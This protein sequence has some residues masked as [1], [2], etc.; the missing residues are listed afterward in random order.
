MKKTLCLTTAFFLLGSAASQ[1]SA[2]EQVDSSGGFTLGVQQVEINRNSAKFN[3][4]R[5]IRDGFYLYDFWFDL[6]ADREFVMFNGSN[7]LRDDQSIDFRVGAFGSWSFEVNRNEIPH[8]LSN[9]ARTPFINQGDGLFTVPSPVG[10][11]VTDVG[12]PAVATSGYNLAPTQAQAN[13]GLL[14][15]NDAATAA[16]LGTHLRP[17]DLGTQ[18]NKTAGTFRFSP[19]GGLNLS[20]S[21]SDERKDGSKIT[22]GPIGDR[23]PRTLNVQLPEPID[24]VTRELKFAAEYNQAAYQAQFTYLYSDFNNKI[25]TLNWQNIYARTGVE[26]ADP[27]YD[28]WAGHR[29]ATFGQ[30]SLQPDNTYQNAALSLGINLPMA[31]RLAATAAYGLMRQDERLL[32]YSTSSFGTTSLGAARELPRSR[33]D[34]DIDTMLLKVDYTLNPF[35]RLNLRAFFRYYD[36][37][38]DTPRDQ[39]WYV[40][41]DTVV[42]NEAGT[43]GNIPSGNPTSKNQRVSLA[44]A[45]DQM[46]YGLDTSFNLPFWRTTLGLGYEREEID[47]DFREANTDENM[48]RVSV[49]ARPAN[50]VTIRAKY[51]FGDRE[52]DGYNNTVTR[53]SYW[54]TNN[55]TGTELTGTDLDNPLVSFSNHPDMRKYDVS[56]RERNQFDLSTNIMPLSGVNLSTSYLYRK[57]DYGSG[58]RPVAGLADVP[59]DTVRNPTTDAITNVEKGALTP[60]DQLGLLETKTQR[61]AVEA[62]YAANDRLTLTAFGS[63]ETIEA[64]QRGLEFDENFKLN[65][66]NA[67]ENELGPWYEARGQWLAETDDKTNTFGIG[68]G[69]EI[70][71]GRLRLYSDLTLS[72]GKVDIDYSGFGTVFVTDQHG[73]VG[74]PTPEEYQFAF[75]SPATVKHNQYILNA[76]LEYQVV[77]NLVFGLHYLFDR[78]KTS[79]WMEEA[80]GFWVQPVGSEFFLRDTS[81]TGAALPGASTQWGNRLVTMG[82]PLAPSYEAHVASVTMTYR[83]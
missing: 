9:K 60:G 28:Q 47:R 7:L 70:I 17:T 71:P 5:D 11:P 37:N 18:R 66:S 30:R 4:Y 10:L 50:W 52:G 3:E 80:S 68:A 61:Y 21:Y 20:L 48:Y 57:D 34:A 22:Y 41:S 63:R 45:Y 76:S 35:D 15:N 75:R 81:A 44:Y 55:I 36:L 32:P 25:E 23:P 42:G 65:P 39:W 24:Y 83:F 26:L 53:Q 74:E 77:T 19:L 43:T 54:Y 73:V 33:A 1:A 14:T 27:T 56:D 69:Y 16:W 67:Q 2:Q 31:S 72:R 79:D 46:N 49:R 62:V 40:T 6:L 29:V 82:S 13:A 78:L 64:L 59:F 58:V 38:N 51:L 12:E 8:R